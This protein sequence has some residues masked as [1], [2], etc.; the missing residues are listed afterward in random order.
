MIP[1]I[2]FCDRPAG[3]TLVELMIT[4]TVA[5][6]LLALAAP[7]FL[8]AT[9]GAKL[10]AYANNFAASAQ[11]ARSEAIKRNADVVVCVSTNGTT[12]A[13]GGWEQGWI[14]MAGSTVLKHEQGTAS[15][16]KM[17]ASG[18]STSITFKPTGYG[19]SWSGTITVCRK[20]PK[21]GNQERVITLTATGKTQ[22]VTTTSG[23]CS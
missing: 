7:S 5:A 17:T 1:S 2:K 6:V 19:V 9:L 12:C 23:S 16:F 10:N 14:V 3:F 15:G 20:E 13:T 4:L 11:L 21:A 18:G 8:D 22:V